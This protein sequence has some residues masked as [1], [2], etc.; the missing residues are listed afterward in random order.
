MNGLKREY[1]GR[2]TFVQV[3]ILN[4][5]NAALMKEYSF[6]TS[7]E[8]YLVAPG[9]QVLGFWDELTSPDDLRAAIE[10]ALAD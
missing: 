10:A 7:P 9:G 2:V 8:I 5:N 3:N 4:P 6:S 1:S